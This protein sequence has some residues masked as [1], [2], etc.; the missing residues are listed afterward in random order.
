MLISRRDLLRAGA[1][2]SAWLALGARGASGAESAAPPTGPG[3][4][5][6]IGMCDWSL[7]KTGNITMFGLARE[8]GLDG[9]EVS[10]NFPGPGQHLRDPE[11]QRQFKAAMKENHLVAPSVALGI[12]NEV[13]LKSEPKAAIWLADAIDVARALDARVI[14][15]A[16]FGA[17]ELKMDDEK[18][19]ARTVD[20]LKELAPRAAKAQVILGLENTLSAQDNMGILERVGSDWVQVYYDFKNSADFGRDVPAEV[21]LLGKR[22]CQVHLKN[23]AELLSGPGNVNFPACADALREVGYRGWYVLESTSPSGDRVADTRANIEYVRQH[24]S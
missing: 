5:L 9:V 3:A 19:V 20:V 1:A 13:P 10:I 22:I 8:I 11:V 23:G 21:R 2:G 14:L 12:L 18:G 6:R 4:G 17:G 24:F 15:I 7:G 16:F